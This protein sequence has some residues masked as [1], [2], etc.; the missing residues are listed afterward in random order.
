[1]PRTKGTPSDQP[2]HKGHV[3]TTSPEKEGSMF[4]LPH[5][6]SYHGPC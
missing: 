6:D 1:M 5:P 3:Y 2:T 4:G